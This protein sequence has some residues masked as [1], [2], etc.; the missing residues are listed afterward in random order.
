MTRK[1]NDKETAEHESQRDIWQEVLDATARSRL[2][3][4]GGIQ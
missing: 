2:A 3:A 1:L 4:A